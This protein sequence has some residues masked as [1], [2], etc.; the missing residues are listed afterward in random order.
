MRKPGLPPPDRI[1]SSK[2]TQAYLGG[3][4]NRFILK[5]NEEYK[6]WDK[7]KHLKPPTGFSIREVWHAVRHWRTQRAFLLKFGSYRFSFV[8]TQELAHWLH[9]VD[10]KYGGSIGAEETPSGFD[11]QRYLVSSVAEEA[12]ASSQIEGAVTTRRVAKEMLMQQ[13]PPRDRSEQMILNN[14]QT[15]Q[16]IREHAKDN[17]N[18]K[19]L[20]HLHRLMTTKTLHSP[21]EEG[22]LRKDDD[23]AVVDHSDGTIMHRPPLS[24]KLH[25]LLKDLIAFFNTDDEHNFIHPIVKATICHFMI[26]WIHPFVDGNGRTARALFYWYM[27]R[28]GYWLTEY[29]SISRVILRSRGNY[30][31]AFLYTETDNHDL[32]YFIYYHMRALLKA[33]GELMEY[34]ER[35][36]EERVSFST[37]V[38]SGVNER[39]A[40]ILGWVI[41]EPGKVIVVKEV[42]TQFGVSNQTARTDLQELVEK[43]YLRITAPNKKKQAFLAAPNLD[44]KLKS[45]TS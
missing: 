28:N 31:R 21:K 42:Q 41:K 22:S 36:S 12:I 38:R 11:R 3:K 13:R 23:I 5:V 32:N 45:T 29:L 18:L 8:W 17:L 40:V 26:S 4:W 19:K 43:G 37:F 35:K 16:W 27:L 30:Y 7:V 24:K 6:H 10:M 25:V 44:R 39:Q 15:I 33:F 9:E 34:I 14:Y 2:A 1:L 20:L